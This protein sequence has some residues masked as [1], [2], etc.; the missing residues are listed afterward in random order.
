MRGGLIK[1]KEERKSRGVEGGGRAMIDGSAATV[2]RQVFKV[3]RHSRGPA[4]F[5]AAGR[6]QEVSRAEE[7]VVAAHS[8]TRRAISPASQ[9]N[10]EEASAIR[11]PTARAVSLSMAAEQQGSTSGSREGENTVHIVSS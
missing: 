4:P 3:Q 11:R 1:I 2:G 6:R 7:S 10:T 8:Q 5:C 9:Q